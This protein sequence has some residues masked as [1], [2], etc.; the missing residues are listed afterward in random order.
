MHLGAAYHVSMVEKIGGKRAPKVFIREWLV[1][2]EMTQDR[3]AERMDVS[4]GTISKLINGHMA[5]DTEYLAGA[6]EAFS[7][8]IEDMFRDP[9]APTQKDLLRQAVRNM[10][11][12]KVADVINII[13]ALTGTNG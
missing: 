5:W 13:R 9:R 8:E 6:A 2:R 11:D 12:D 1:F 10:P 4:K 3:L 7:I